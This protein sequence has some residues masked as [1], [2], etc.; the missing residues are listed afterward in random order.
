MGKGKN[1]ELNRLEDNAKREI[2]LELWGPYV[3]ERQWGT[4]REDYSPNGD[5]W[6]YFP[7]DH[8]RSRAYIWGEDGLAAISDCYQ[9][10]CF[11]IALWNGQDPILKE[12][13]FGLTNPEGNHG[14]DVKELYFHLDN[15]PS[16]YYMKYL[17][18]YP[19]GA[20]PYQSL[21]TENN[22]L[23]KFQPEFEILDTGIFD[24]DRYFDVLT[25]YA[26]KDEEDIFIKI[27]IKNR[28]KENAEI[29]L[30]PS[31]WYYNKWQYNGLKTR[32]SMTR[33]TT[34]AIELDHEKM[35]KYFFYFQKSSD[36][37]LTENETNFQKLFHLLNQFEYVKD[38]FHDAIIHGLNYQKLTE[39]KSGTKSALVYSENIEGGDSR[40]FYFRLKKG[41]EKKPFYNGFEQIFDIR[42]SEVDLFYKDLLQPAAPKIFH[43]K[44]MALSG[45]LWSRQYYY[46]DIEWWLNRSD[47]ITPITPQRLNGRNKNWKYL[48]NQDILSMPDKW[49][50]PWYAAWDSA[51]HAIT[52]AMVDPTFAK[53]QLT[54][55]MREWYMNQEGQL[56]AYEWDFNDVNPPI[57]AFAAYEIYKIER[58]LYGNTDIHFLKSIFQKLIINFTWWVNR[59][60]ANGNN[61][62]EGG[63]LGLDNIGLFN[64]NTDLGQDI[65]LEQSDGTS[66]MGMYA[67]NMMEIACEIANQD[68]AYEDSVTKFYEHF[69]II[70]EALNSLELW[71][72]EDEFFYDVLAIK[73]QGNLPLKV[74]SLVGLIPIF[75]VGVFD[76]E[77][78]ANLKDFHKRMTWFE[79]YRRRHQ[80]YSPNQEISGSSS[81]LLSMLSADRLKAILRRVLDE[82][83]FLAPHGIRSLSKYY[84]HHPYNLNTQNGK[85]SIAY[86]AGESTSGMYGGNSNWRGPIWMPMNYMLIKALYK[87]GRFYGESFLIDYP[88]G[89]NTPITLTEVALRLTERITM[90]FIP[91]DNNKIPV[92]DNQQWF[93]QGDDE[94]LPAFYEYFHADSG[95]GLGASHQ[96]GWTALIVNLL[97]DYKLNGG[98]K[99]G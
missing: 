15:L 70:A 26:K 82:K 53:H 32:P 43:L 92:H 10:I 49:E 14:E 48:K 45:L 31:I 62:F 25:E 19:H 90:L 75:A 44:K 27:T 99:F 40:I 80:L 3:S 93:F 23:N 76:I 95:K 57:H 59:K 37:L 47:G 6:N 7:H 73:G 68:H 89:S 34:N 78:I 91:D 17:Y 38:A 42:S 74:R 86:E 64:R 65:I 16:H 67:L 13:L 60:D 30:I 55:L 22:K 51:F 61:I 29:K 5:A 52:L 20:Y 66:W 12:R 56:P 41:S 71:N 98:Q 97:E 85:F 84:E 72:E 18:K 28:G 2:P 81:R 46:F 54:L 83:E 8:A 77:T 58:D 69:V 87:Y 1:I 35:G 79:N 39:H 50:Y 63:F 36:V 94:K 88:T 11:G 33:S 24:D 9:N 21:I 96:T 4:V